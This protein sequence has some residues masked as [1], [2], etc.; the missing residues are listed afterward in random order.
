LSPKFNTR[1]AYVSTGGTPNTAAYFRGPTALFG[2]LQ[3]HT[4]WDKWVV[5]VEYDGNDY[6]HEPQ[7]NNRVQQTPFNLGLTY[8]LYPS[9]QLSM[10]VER[11]NAVV[12]GLTLHTSVAQMAAPKVSDPPAPKINA[13]PMYK[14]IGHTAGVD[15]D[16]C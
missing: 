1:G 16:S 7:A 12:F 13:Q 8:Q 14:K 3:Y 4:P 5:K 2:G 6:Q 11:G 15:D 9:T 10:G